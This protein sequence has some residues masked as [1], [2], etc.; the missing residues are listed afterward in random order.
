[1]STIPD[2]SDP[3]IRAMVLRNHQPR[4]TW[5]HRGEES[6]VIVACGECG[7]PWRCASFVAAQADLELDTA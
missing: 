1:M 4:E 6:Y 3:I 2:I 5:Y 7:Q